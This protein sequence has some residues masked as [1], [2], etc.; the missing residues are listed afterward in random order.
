[1]KISVDK[2]IV[3]K[4]TLMVDSM[5]D[6]QVVA[7]YFAYVGNLDGIVVN[8]FDTV[9]KRLVKIYQD[10]MAKDP[11]FGSSFRLPNIVPPKIPTL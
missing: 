4:T 6:R 8:D 11:S 2:S 7:D 10:R 5:T 3:R 9:R 1:M